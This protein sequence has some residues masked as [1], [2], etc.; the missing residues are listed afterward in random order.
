MFLKMPHGADEW[1]FVNLALVTHLV[2]HQE[3]HEVSAAEAADGR[4]ATGVSVTFVFSGGQSVRVNNLA[5][6]QVKELGRAIKT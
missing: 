5:P 6:E 2:W 4:A 1:V 3:V